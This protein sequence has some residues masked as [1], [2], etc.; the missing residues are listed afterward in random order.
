LTRKFGRIRIA[1]VRLFRRRPSD[2][3]S[4]FLALVKREGPAVD[5]E[6]GSCSSNADAGTEAASASDSETDADASEPPGGFI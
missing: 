1:M 2:M 6:C 4:L 5:V 3:Y